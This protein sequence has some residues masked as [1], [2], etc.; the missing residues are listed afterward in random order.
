M[1][2]QVSETKA[3]LL[4]FAFAMVPYIAVAWGYC[5]FTDGGPPTFWRAIGVLLAV[6]LF[7]E[8]IEAIGRFL[9]WQLFVRQRMVAY[10]LSVFKKSEFPPKQ[11]HDDDFG[12]YSARLLGNRPSAPD[13][14][15]HVQDLQALLLI[16]EKRGIFD[17]LRMH[18]VVDTAFEKYMATMPK[19]AKS[20]FDMD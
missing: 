18:S 20:R 15:Q 4:G 16:N 9:A 11:Y 13:Y 7:F 2:T 1:G 12:N 3:A 14:M 5:Y 10:V 19:A 17:G 6:R 8:V